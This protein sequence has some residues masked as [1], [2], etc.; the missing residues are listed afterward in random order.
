M[1]KFP[2]TIEHP[3]LD[4]LPL[5][6]ESNQPLAEYFGLEEL[7]L[8]RED[9]LPDLGGKK[10]RSL[11]ALAKALPSEQAVHV[12][13]YAGSNT[14]HTLARLR[15]DC[16]IVSHGKFYNGGDYMRYAVSSLED[17]PNVIQK[18]GPLP[19]VLL[20]Y[21]WARYVIHRSHIYLKTGGRLA[22]DNA[23][24]AAAELV[25]SAI[26]G[27]YHHFLPVASGNLLEAVRGQFSQTTG[28]LT[29]PWYI[30]IFAWLKYKRVAGFY[31]SSID[32]RISLV[33]NIF[34]KTD[35]ALDPIFMGPVMVYL[36]RLVNKPKKVCLWVTCSTLA[37]DYHL[38]RK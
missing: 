25:K 34:K 14:A 35:I 2:L 12:L 7:L 23:Y 1:S 28:I 26:G 36:Q 22:S 8:I 32:S 33:R 30:K 38:T 3:K 15:R 4:S 11:A 10:R 16:E 19:V 20:S 9:L 18:N 6:I 31:E 13:S 17:R 24:R 21:F 5:R 37:R 27:D 29:Q